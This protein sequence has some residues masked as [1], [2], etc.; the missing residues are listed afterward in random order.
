[1][2][3]FKQF[4]EMI[5]LVSLGSGLDSWDGTLSGGILCLLVDNLCAILASMVVQGRAAVTT[6]LKTTFKKRMRTP[7]LALCRA[8]ITRRAGRKLWI[9]GTVEDGGWKG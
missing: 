4:P 7:D 8:Q 6:E 1:M 9:R 5:T 2:S 3:D